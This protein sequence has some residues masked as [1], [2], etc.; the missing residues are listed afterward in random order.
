MYTCFLTRFPK[1]QVGTVMPARDKLIRQPGHQREAGFWVYFR[2]RFFS[3]SSPTYIQDMGPLQWPPTLVNGAAYLVEVATHELVR[4]SCLQQ[5]YVVDQHESL[6]R[7]ED[8]PLKVTLSH[9]VSNAAAAPGV[10]VMEPVAPK[11][12]NGG[13][14]ASPLLGVR[15]VRT[16]LPRFFP[17]FTR[18]WLDFIAGGFCER[19]LPL[20]KAHH[21]NVEDT[22]GLPLQQGLA[23]SP[24]AVNSSTQKRSPTKAPALPPLV[25]PSGV[26]SGGG[27]AEFTMNRFLVRSRLA[28]AVTTIP[29]FYT[30]PP[31]TVSADSRRGSVFGRRSNCDNRTC[32]LLYSLFSPFLSSL[33]L[34][35]S[36]KLSV[37][38]CPTPVCLSLRSGQVLDQNED[39]RRQGHHGA[40]QVPRQ[41]RGGREAGHRARHHRQA[42]RHVRGGDTHTRGLARRGGKEAP[43]E[44]ERERER[45]KE[46]KARDMCYLTHKETEG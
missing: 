27:W 38:L 33:V 22:A 10:L 18:T 14:S 1:H 19:A 43:S 25:F 16:A 37:L 31:P 29:S 35:S 34:S 12:T 15:A 20:W 8:L 41:G 44:R 24:Q 40:P 13:E 45:E 9:Y 26:N 5:V 7:G 17:S 4:V 28:L 46:Q 36:P 2:L 42:Y 21:K 30:P 23:A 3:F 39:H 6:Q 11:I 32:T